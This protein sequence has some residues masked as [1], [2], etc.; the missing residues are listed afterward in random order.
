M[1]FTDKE[2]NPKEYSP[3]PLAYIGD[4]VYDLFIRTKV[5][6]KGNRHVTDLHK[7]SVRFVKAHSQAESVHTIEQRLTENEIRVLKWGRNAKSTPPKNADVTDYR[8]ATGF[9]TLLGYLY[10][11]GNIDRLKEIMNMAYDALCSQAN[12]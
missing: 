1:L 5:I 2:I 9:E 11:E 10:L 6:E 12:G 7:E 3:L 8:Y 4:S